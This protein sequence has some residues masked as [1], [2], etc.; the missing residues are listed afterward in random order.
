MMDRGTQIGRG[1]IGFPFAG[2]A[3]GQ[4]LSASNAVAA[5]SWSY[6]A[7]GRA[8]NETARAS[9]VECRVSYALSASALATNTALSVG[10]WTL[11]VER[12]FD[13]AGRLSSLTSPAGTFRIAYDGTNGLPSVVTNAALSE[14]SAYD[15]LGR[16]TNTVCR[17]ASGE[18]VAS[19]RY[20]YDAS[21]F[22]TQK[23]ASVGGSAVTHA[24]AYDALGRLVSESVT[25]AVTSFSYDSAGNRTVVQSGTGNLPV[26]STYVNNRLVS[27]ST[28]G[29]F[30]SAVLYDGAGNV[31]SLVSRAGVTLSLYW[32]TLGQLVSV[33]TNGAFAESYAYDAL[34]RRISTTSLSTTNHQPS[35]IDHLYDG[36]QCI[37]DM[38]TSG[39]LLRAYTWGPGTN[40]LLAVTIYS[41][42]A[43]NTYY[44]VRD[45]LGSVYA[46]VN[47][48]GAVV[49][50]YAYDAWGSVQ[51]VIGNWQSAIGNRFM[52]HG[53]AYSAATG[54]YQFRARWYAPELGRWLSPDPIG[55]EGGLNLYEF[56]RNNPVNGRDPS[57][58]AVWTFG[59]S[60]SFV[61]GMGADISG[62]VIVAKDLS[63]CEFSY[64]GKSLSMGA[65]VGFDVGVGVQF[66]RFSRTFAIRGLF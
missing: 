37:A 4:A 60:G 32:N 28:N 36:S 65:D 29:A 53:G 25:N 51:S 9:N 17:G 52:F 19:F 10:S 18:T 23:I 7:F 48:S 31:T 42:D 44:A 27:V 34:G 16:L 66:G 13:S 57:G 2:N 43:T 40:N 61:F 47:S 26:Q 1:R 20:R 55:L 24:Y 21:G 49:E 62:G 11:S 6:D 38:D 39:N 30:A 59:G 14:C 5:V 58:K 46:L 3:Q 45:R 15:V 54:L 35:T 33:S 8:T 41:A 64:A 50:S 63:S 22:V 12:S 56:C